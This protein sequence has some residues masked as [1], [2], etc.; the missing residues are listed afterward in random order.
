M[1]PR[2]DS[3]AHDTR[4]AWSVVKEIVREASPSTRASSNRSP[5]PRAA[6]TSSPYWACRTSRARPLARCSSVR[7]SRT[8]A[9]AAVKSPGR[10]DLPSQRWASVSADT[11]CTSRRPPAPCLRSGS[12]RWAI[13]PARWRLAAAEAT[14]SSYREAIWPR[15][16]RRAPSTTSAP[17][18]G[19]PASTRASSR[20]SPAQT[21]D[22][23]TA[24]LWST[25][26]TLWSSPIPESQSGYH[27]RSAIAASSR[28]GRRS[29]TSSRSRS[30]NG[31]TS[32]RPSPPSAMRANPLP[33]PMPASCASKP[34]SRS[35]NAHNV[36]RSSAA[37]RSA[38]PRLSRSARPSL[39]ACAR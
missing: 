36:R 9:C 2:V 35:Y 16:W 1:S 4:R 5:T 29:W 28:S 23:A 17:R 31:R 13:T 32:R 6:P 33:C 30:E 10:A 38:W 21:S 25:V 14:R 15:H 7:A 18:S 26:R 22:A 39:S 11:S 37:E 3:A 24:R 34:S 27:R 20:L 8:R 12:V 19:S